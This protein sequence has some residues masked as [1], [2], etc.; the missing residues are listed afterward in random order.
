MAGC[1]SG[2]F[3]FFSCLNC[4]ALYQIVKVGAGPET[5]DRVVTCLLCGASLPSRE[6]KFVLKYS[7]LRK[8]G[9][10]RTDNKRGVG[11]GKV[12]SKRSPP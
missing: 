3:V 5:G 11:G 7:L 9:R 12:M 10:G 6:G 4:K 8:A 1:R 2:S